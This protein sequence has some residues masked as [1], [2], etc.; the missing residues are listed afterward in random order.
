MSARRKWI[1]LAGAAVIFTSAAA[2]APS[3]LRRFDSFAVER[4]EIHG[5]RYLAPFDAFVQSGITKNSN[6]FDDFE[7]WRARLLEHPMILDASIERHLPGTVRVSIAEAK[8]IA[9]ARTP[10]LRPVDA[11]AQ[12]LPIDPA[13]ADLDLPLLRME[14]QPDASGVFT[15]APTR[16]VIGVLAALHRNDARLFSWVSEAGVLRDH[17]VRLELRQP[18][19]AEAWIPAD[20]RASRLAELH[21]ALADLAAR[22]ELSRLKRIDA[23]FHDQIVV[24]LTIGN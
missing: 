18:L 10:E 11:R 13:T 24:V 8:P 3:V 5:T 15:D 4:V 22:G 14:S 23:R 20:P 12:A 19:G 9:L 7:G 17:G 16:E 6:V 21:V 2:A 1:V